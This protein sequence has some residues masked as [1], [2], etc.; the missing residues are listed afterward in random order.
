MGKPECSP[1]GRDHQCRFAT[2][3]VLVCGLSSM[4]MLW[5][6]DNTF[7]PVGINS[8]PISVNTPPIITVE[9][10][11]EDQAISQGESFIIRWTDVDPDS[12][13]LISI[14]LVE[15]DGP[16][17]FLVAGGI[18]ENDITSDLFKVDT[19]DIVLGTFFV[20]LTIDDEINAAVSVYAEEEFTGNRVKIEITE[21]GLG[22]QN[23]PPQVY[24]SAPSFNIS[25]SQNDMLTVAIRPRVELPLNVA[26]PSPDFFYDPDGEAV[27]AVLALDMDDDPSNDDY[28]VDDDGGNIILRRITIEAGRFDTVAFQEEIDVQEVPVR[29]S[30]LPYYVR[31]T[32][33]DGLNTVHSYAAGR[34]HVLRLVEGSASSSVQRIDL[35][36]IGKLYSGACFYGFNPFANLGSKMAS[37]MDQDLDGTGDVVMIAQYGNPRNIGNIGEAYMLYGLPGQR[38]GGDIPINS[39][40][41]DLPET[42][43]NRVRGSVFHPHQDFILGGIVD[44]AA[45]D[46]LKIWEVPDFNLTQPYTLGITDVVAIKSL[47][48][49]AVSAGCA[50]PE[51]IFGMPHNEYM[52]GTHDDDPIDGDEGFYSYGDDLPNN[53]CD[54]IPTDDPSPS[55]GAVHYDLPPGTHVAEERSGSVALWYGDNNPIGTNPDDDGIT[56]ANLQTPNTRVYALTAC[57]NQGNL[58]GGKLHMGARFSVAIFDYL[59]FENPGMAPFRVDPLNSHYG[60]NV[61]VLPDI[62]MNGLDELVISAPRNEIETRDLLEEFTDSHPHIASRLARSNI[63][64]WLGQDFNSITSLD[65]TAHFPFTASRTIPINCFGRRRL[66]TQYETSASPF[67][68]A[69]AVH[70]NA[71]NNVIVPPGWFMI[72]GASPEDKLGGA[73][74]AG[75]FNLD[76]PS[77]I[78]AGAP[79]YNPLIDTTGNGFGDTLVQDAGV[80]Y[81]VYL[82]WPFGNTELASA[83]VVDIEI[84]RAPMLRIFGESANDHLG[85]RQENAGDVNLDSIED[86]LIASSDYNGMG[87]TNNGFVGRVFG[88]QR[89]DGD[90]VVSQ[91]ATSELNGVRFYGNNTGDL[92]GAD[93][94]GAG[95]FNGDG[96]GDI[97]VSAPGEVISMPSEDKPRRGVTY[98]IFGGIHLGNKVFTLSQVG[99]SSLPGLVFAGP[100]QEDTPDAFELDQV[101]IVID[102]NCDPEDDIECV[103]NP[104]IQ[105]GCT[106]LEEADGTPLYRRK[107]DAAP[108]RVAFVGDLNGDGFDDIMIGNP[109]ADFFDPQQPGTAR[110]TDTGEVYLVYG[111]NFGANTLST[112]IGE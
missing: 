40:A 3:T 107:A 74:S 69:G 7:N 29:E 53:L 108:S 26:N 36:K 87:L 71:D 67:N 51:L 48:S 20:R 15:S 70:A 54:Q 100:Y 57:G 35:N 39:L 95:D 22:T 60:M 93:I 82:R 2:V 99:S 65:T 45:G 56:C 37:A 112:N 13:A 63:V 68:A 102:E 34:V 11:N 75:D 24:V 52:G 16:N 44:I 43:Y 42:S 19:E 88:G 85:L 94:A 17:V 62:D 8:P 105:E 31:I 83:D 109:T 27:D 6:C 49:G 47:G 14:E 32:V 90:R 38:F 59:A 5:A 89:I 12:N 80:V 79:F 9:E 25:V 23:I 84:P 55:T 72:R 97:M 81:I 1:A 92:A 78:L 106:I 110:R 86:V 58:D 46:D 101:V 30:G 73:R 64:G 104:E 76:G 50:V 4:I 96:I 77:D 66:E 41:T 61:A 28:T 111:N 21:P 10:P 33:S 98:L 103:C 91:I 18:R